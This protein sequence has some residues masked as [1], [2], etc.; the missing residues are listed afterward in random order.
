MAVGDLTVI[1]DSI[2][3][4]DCSDNLMA[5]EA[6]QKVFVVNGSNLKVIDFKNCELTHTAL[7]TPHANGDVL[8][9]ATSAAVMY[10]EYTNAAKTKTYGYVTNGT[11]DTS[12]EVTG[13]GSGT[14]FTPT[15]YSIF[16]ST[17]NEFV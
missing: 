12:H 13:D 5:F 4:I 10:V 7:T 11:F 6:F 16:L 17:T 9:Q 8:T 2:S 14:A 1:T 15:R 3:D